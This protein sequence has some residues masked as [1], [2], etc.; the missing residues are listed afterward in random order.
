MP[1]EICQQSNEENVRKFAFNRPV[2]CTVY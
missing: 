2:L 1:V